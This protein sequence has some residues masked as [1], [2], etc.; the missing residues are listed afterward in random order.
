MGATLPW[1]K[2]ARNV[3][4]IDTFGISAPISVMHEHFGFT[5]EKLVEDYKNIK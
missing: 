2:Y 5:V 3:K 4:G 1:Y